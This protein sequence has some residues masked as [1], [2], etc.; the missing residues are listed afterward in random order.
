MSYNIFSYVQSLLIS[1][2]FCPWPWR[3]F[4][5][6]ACYQSSNQIW[7]VV[8]NIFYFSIDLGNVI[9]PV[10]FHIFERGG[11]TTN[12]DVFFGGDVMKHRTNNR[13]LWWE[14]FDG[15]DADVRWNCSTT[16]M[17]FSQQK[18]L[19][20]GMKWDLVGI[21]YHNFRLVNHWCSWTVF[22]SYVKL[23]QGNHQKS[24]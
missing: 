10:D 18:L 4:F 14:Y 9:I 12:E 17:K 3:K 24:W 22:H 19:F 1:T 7:L 6:T 15:E 13:S 5:Q 20:T 23:P 21:P 2:L 16:M 11:S 8:W